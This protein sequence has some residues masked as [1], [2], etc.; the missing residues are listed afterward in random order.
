MAREN[1]STPHPHLARRCTAAAV[2]LFSIFVWFTIYSALWQAQVARHWLHHAIL[3]L[4]GIAALVLPCLAIWLL[5]Q[6][7]DRIRHYRGY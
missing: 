6:G 4:G 2:A 5:A 3:L 1:S 7:Y